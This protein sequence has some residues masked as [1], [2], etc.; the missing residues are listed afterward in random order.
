MTV[1]LFARHGETEHTKNDIFSGRKSDPLPTREGH[2]GTKVF[3]KKLVG[4]LDA[5][6]TSRLERSKLFGKYYKED[7]DGPVFADPRLDE[8]DAGIFEGCTSEDFIKIG[9]EEKHRNR[10]VTPLP[11]G[12][13][14]RE[15]AI[16]VIQALKFWG[17][18]FPDCD[19]LVGSHTDVIRAVQAAQEIALGNKTPYFFGKD[20]KEEDEMNRGLPTDL[21]LTVPIPYFYTVEINPVNFVLAEEK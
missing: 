12:E 5:C 1:F 20:I 15:V 18:Q 6:L 11:C 7:Y 8:K 14:H 13:T 4:F 3:I 10:W 9:Y 2:L 19:V 17:K 16:R 21:Q